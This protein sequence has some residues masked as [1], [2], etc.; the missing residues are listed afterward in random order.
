MSLFVVVV[1]VKIFHNLRSGVVWREYRQAASSIPVRR[2]VLP[3]L[4]KPRTVDD[5]PL[6]R[7]RSG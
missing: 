3:D 1:R 6:G 7:I 4:L 2:K 5:E